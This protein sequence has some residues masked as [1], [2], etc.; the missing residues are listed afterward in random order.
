MNNHRANIA[1]KLGVPT[2]GL[3]LFIGSFHAVFAPPAV[4]KRNGAVG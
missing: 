1:K 2:A 3:D 4:K